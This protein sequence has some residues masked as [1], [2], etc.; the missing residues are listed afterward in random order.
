MIL[1]SAASAA[2]L[3]G[4]SGETRARRNSTIGG[5]RRGSIA[6]SSLGNLT[7]HKDLIHECLEEAQELAAAGGF[8]V[9]QRSDAKSRPS[10]RKKTLQPVFQRTLGVKGV[11]IAGA[12]GFVGRMMLFKMLTHTPDYCKVY[13]LAR[14]DAEE[15]LEE[16]FEKDSGLNLL[17]L[18]KR[19]KVI[20]VSWD[21]VPEDLGM[22]EETLAELKKCNIFINCAGLTEWNLP[23]EEVDAI[24]VDAT[25]RLRK[26]FAKIGM[27]VQFSSAY[28][29]SFLGRHTG[30]EIHEKQYFT[31]TTSADRFPNTYL[32]SKAKMEEYL[33][34]MQSKKGLGL[35]LLVRPSLISYSYRDPYPGW[36][37][38]TEGINAMMYFL[39]LGIVRQLRTKHQGKM[40]LDV[41]PVDAVAN[42]AFQLM[43]NVAI[44]AGEVAKLQKT[45][46]EEA[47]TFGRNP[48]ICHCCTSTTNP[49]T[50]VD[51]M[52]Q[53]CHVFKK[54]PLAMS[55][56]EPSVKMIDGEKRF[57]IQH[58]L[59][60]S[61][62]AGVTQNK[63]A[64]KLQKLDTEIHNLFGF[65]FTS[66]LLF[67]TSYHAL[68]TLWKWDESYFIPYL[69]HLGETMTDYYDAHR[70]ER[71]G[72]KGAAVFRSA[73]KN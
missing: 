40:V 70:Q 58:F 68:T 64:V 47:R 28:V 3:F 11:V 22:S 33:S 57:A 21:M 59:K 71:I 39:G 26:K 62:K 24:N 38:C 35:L 37:T 16:L 45:K 50:V 69:E 63:S 17:P 32:Y 14:G 15:R 31:M 41:V 60:Y 25:I 52:D 56:G 36:G 8:K 19:K 4:M 66:E 2:K 5:A 54:H 1:L 46:P 7:K 51:F 34:E 30:S 55:K 72:E 29:N 18:E 20:A 61:L 67:R 65:F 13:A 42:M 53:A 10:E 9:K 6:P 48:F 12:C 23:Q 43:L 27:F 73:M 49:I 44:D